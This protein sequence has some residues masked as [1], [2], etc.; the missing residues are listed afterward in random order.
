[1]IRCMFAFL[2]LWVVFKFN[3]CACA[4][5]VIG[6]VWLLSYSILVVGVISVSNVYFSLLRS[7]AVTPNQHFS[8]QSIH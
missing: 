7:L 4:C 6:A 3:L 1:V 2:S 8:Q 5:S